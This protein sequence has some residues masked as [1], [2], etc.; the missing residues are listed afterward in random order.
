MCAYEAPSW[1]WIDGMATLTMLT[2]TICMKVAGSTVARTANGRAGDLGA[3]LVIEGAGM[4]R[5]TPDARQ[6]PLPQV[7]AR[8]DPPAQ[9]G[10]GGARLHDA[11]RAGRGTGGGPAAAASHLATRH[12]ARGLHLPRMRVHRVLHARSRF[13]P[14][15]WRAGGPARRAGRPVPLRARLPDRVS[16]ATAPAGG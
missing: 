7:P 12:A 6:S 15:G 8:R 13:D 16:R 11:R 4:V 10:R 5:H 1:R 3:T 14:G 9:A 2:S